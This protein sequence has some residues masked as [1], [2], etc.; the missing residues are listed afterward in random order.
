MVDILNW[1]FP[2][3][4]TL[5]S[6]AFYINKL[7][8]EGVGDW[9]SHCFTAAR[10]STAQVFPV[11]VSPF[12]FSLCQSCF[13]PQPPGNF[14]STNVSFSVCFPRSLACNGRYSVMLKWNRTI[15]PISPRTRVSY[16]I[17]R[18]GKSVY[19]HCPMCLIDCEASLRNP[20]EGSGQNNTLVYPACS[21][22]GRREGRGLR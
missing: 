4:V 16:G 11:A 10:S 14:L 19:E 1:L 8:K 18:E 13:L 7:S 20:S 2:G 3:R 12:S 15:E 22:P 9:S 6:L 21:R 5:S 17:T